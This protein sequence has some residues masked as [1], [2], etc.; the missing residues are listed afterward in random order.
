LQ[1]YAVD[2]NFLDWKAT[3]YELESYC[4][5][6]KEKV[7]EGGDSVAFINPEIRVKYV[8]DMKAILEWIDDAGETA[9]LSEYIEKLKSIK[10]IGEPI[11]ARFRFIEQ[12]PD[13]RK[14][15]AL[16]LQNRVL[17]KEVASI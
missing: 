17:G 12:Y 8:E 3:K 1:L 11:I 14:A 5:T 7:D 13:N 2:K 6:M 9:P 4:Y 15:L 10:D 16:E